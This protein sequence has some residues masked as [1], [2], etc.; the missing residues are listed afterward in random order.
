MQRSSGY[1]LIELLLLITVLSVIASISMLTI[2][3]NAE[4]RKIDQASL[5]MQHVLESALSYN[6]A[7]NGDWPA[8]NNNLPDCNA[9][10]ADDEFIQH[11]LPNGSYTSHYGNHFCWSKITYGDTHPLFWVALRMPFPDS[12]RNFQTAMRIAAGLPNAAAVMNPNNTSNDPS[13]RCNATSAS[14]YVRSEVSIPGQSA[15]GQSAN[16]VVGLGYCNPTG[17]DVQPGSSDNVTC[18]H[19]A[20]P[21]Q[22]IIRFPCPS[23]ENGLVYA[24]ANFYQA[25]GLGQYDTQTILTVLGTQTAGNICTQ[26][27]DTSNFTCNLSVNAKYDNGIPVV[28]PDGLNPGTIGA[29]YIAYCVK[30]KTHRL[31]STLW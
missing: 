25:A 21:D 16:Q 19:G 6:V 1:T 13:N 29:T 31:T 30:P 27:R 28:H 10:A 7:K 2:R 22:Y 3:K 11:F 14:C 17:A 15:T 5:E 18:A 9:S 12:V 20:S 8:E 24:I 4:N 23:G 26:D